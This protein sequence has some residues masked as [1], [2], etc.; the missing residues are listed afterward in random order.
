[1]IPIKCLIDH[2]GEARA[3]LGL[4]AIPDCLYEQ[5]GEQVVVEGELTKDVEN[6]SGGEKA[7]PTYGPYR[8]GGGCGGDCA[9]RRQTAPSRLRS[10]DAGRADV[11][12][13]LLSSS[14]SD[15]ATAA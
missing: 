7:L 9:G 1:M 4:V 11:S 3:N 13:G 14:P 5:V 12:V 8:S 6:L 2:A 15:W 10:R